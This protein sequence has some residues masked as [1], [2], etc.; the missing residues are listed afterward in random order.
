MYFNLVLMLRA[1][2]RAGPYLEA[3]DIQTGDVQWD[4]EAKKGL[5]KVVEASHVDGEV[6]DEAELF[7]GNDALVSLAAS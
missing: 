7:R 2:S 5:K 4:A 3:Y 1:V 6:F